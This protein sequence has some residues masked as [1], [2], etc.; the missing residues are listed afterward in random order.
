[1]TLGARI[2][3]ALIVAALLPMAVVLAVPLWQAQRRAADE[4]ARRLAQAERQAEILAD[5]ER[6]AL[7]AAAD[8]ARDDLAA[9]HDAL[10]AVVRG[11]EGAAHAAAAALA[12][13]N[14]LDR[15]EI[16]AGSGVPLASSGPLALPPRSAALVE[17][18]ALSAD[19]ETLNLAAT[20]ILDAAFASRVGAVTGGDAHIGGGCASPSVE[21][22]LV[23]GTAL[24]V[25]VA[26]ADAEDVRRDMLRTFGGVAPAAAL[27]A[28]LIGGLIASR[29]ARPIRALARRAEEISAERAHPI[30]LLP[31][32]DE[33]RRL[34][35][36]FDQMLDALAASER[37]RLAA[38]RAAAWEEMAR[39]LAH[40]IKNPLSPIRL[41][42]ENLRK[43]RERT[44]EAFDR[45]FREETTTILEE[46]AALGRLIDEFAAFARLP[47]PEVAA[48]DPRAIA[49]QAIGLFAARI[50]EMG[51]RAEIDDA[52]APSTLRADA[53]QI[54]RVL[55]NVVANA[56]DAMEASPRR[57]LALAIR[58]EGGSAVFEVRDTGTGLDDEALRRL[59]EPYFTTRGGRGGTGLG[60]AIAR[61][62]V[63]EHG[64][65]I[66]AARARDGGA[67]LS[68]A[69]PLDGPPER[70]G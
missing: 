22:A 23:P 20:R 31:E 43:V 1:M 24:C 26:A 34:T 68:I 64:G 55:K 14:G 45:A 21:I 47:R 33:T 63:A 61:R 36:A 50:E 51:V 57:E 67:V 27:A 53:E 54:G 3:G 4:T 44:P 18:R 49:R 70:R 29:I 15:V 12:A 66:R 42:V 7:R 2:V 16:A 56:L 30:T 17:S 10:A 41:G 52:R 5:D 65:S 40:E 8:R 6:R 38:E 25:G 39:R 28:V 9:D 13:R 60:M 37:Q 58:S 11:P 69:L 35:L 59:F 46:V 48:C 19:G 62:I 32:R